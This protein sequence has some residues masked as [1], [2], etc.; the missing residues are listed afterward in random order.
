MQPV[1]TVGLF[2]EDIREEKSG[3]DT[4]IGILPD[5][6]NIAPIPGHHPLGGMP[7]FPKLALYVRVHFDVGDKPRD[8]SLKLINT[9]SRTISE[10]GWSQA[11]IDKAFSDAKNDQTPIVG[12]IQ[13][14]IIAPFPIAGSGK[15]LAVAIVNGVEHVAA[16]MNVT[17]L[18]ATASA[19]PASQ[20]PSAAPASS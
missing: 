15:V 6:V 18:G 8:I 1:S 11:V 7:L 14:I 9:D 17:V 4:L 10:G 2:C 5:N 20:S 3:Q 12:L 19:P 16:V 13:K